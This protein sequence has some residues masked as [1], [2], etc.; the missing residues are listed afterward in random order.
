MAGKKKGNIPRFISPP[1][2]LKE[3]VGEGGIPAHLLLKAQKEIEENKH[4]LKPF[5]E[6]CLTKLIGCVEHG[7][8]H[9]A[10]ITVQ[11]FMKLVMP[12][13]ANGAMFQYGLITMTA[14]VILRFLDQVNH[15]NQDALNILE[16]HNNILAVILKK[17][18]TGTG[19]K[20]GQI[21]TDELQMA[22]SR[23]YKKYKISVT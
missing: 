1:N 11:D 2:L 3:K 10:D 22:C 19:G 7:R 6:D 17:E 5:A 9:P 18:F 20:Q 12:L 8:L 14:D 4:N 16:M 13:K 15:I 23:Y 21:L